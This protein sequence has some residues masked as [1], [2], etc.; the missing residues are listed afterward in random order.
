MDEPLTPAGLEASLRAL[1]IQDRDDGVSAAVRARLLQEVRTVRLARRRTVL[2]SWLLM[3]ALTLAIIVPVWQLAV[4]ETPRP[5]SPQ[6]GTVTPEGEL[7]T[8]FYPLDYSMVPMSS[9]RLVRMEVPVSALAAFGLSDAA[10]MS[11]PTFTN[12]LLADVLV[13]DDG[14]ARAVRFVRPVRIESRKES[15]R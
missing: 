4:L 11:E 9:S 10:E 12:T 8:A 15:L 5:Q 13:G 6:S 2:K 1:A 7:V 3:M 14:L